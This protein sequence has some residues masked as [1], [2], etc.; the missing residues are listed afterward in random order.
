MKD[1]DVIV[2]EISGKMHLFIV[3]ECDCMRL[4][5]AQGGRHRGRYGSWDKEGESGI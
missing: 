3:V 5:T 4:R 2:V 1:N